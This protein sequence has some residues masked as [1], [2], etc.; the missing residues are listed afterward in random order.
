M[1]RRLRLKFYLPAC[2]IS[3]SSRA[4]FEQ[5]KGVSMPSP[6][7]CEIFSANSFDAYRVVPQMP[8]VTGACRSPKGNSEVFSRAPKR[9]A[10]NS[11]LIRVIVLPPE[12]LLHYIPRGR[13]RSRFRLGLV[14]NAARNNRCPVRGGIRTE[15]SHIFRLVFD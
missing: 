6:I 9:S 7:A 2:A 14:R 5:T 10:S 8:H 12:M 4:H 3:S 13:S 11:S 1:V 15:C